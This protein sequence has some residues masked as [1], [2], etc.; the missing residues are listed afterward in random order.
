MTKNRRYSSYFK[1][2]LVLLTIGLIVSF[3]YYQKSSSDF[4][5]KKF[6]KNR[7]TQ[8]ILDWFE[9]D[10]Y[11]LTNNPEF[12][13]QFMIDHMSPKPDPAYFGKQNIVIVYEKDTPVGFGAY[14]MKNFYEGMVHFV[15]IDKHYRRKGYSAKLTQYMI[16]QLIK[17]G[18]KFIK[19]YTRAN[20]MPARA[21]YKKLGFNESEPDDQ[22]FVTLTMRK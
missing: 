21:L 22:G 5:I 11:W 15:Y 9:K 19:L 3:F 2:G 18:A 6:N 7:D 12:S 10:L 14:Y 16:D 8:L 4:Q 13:P 17:M 20:N 1:I